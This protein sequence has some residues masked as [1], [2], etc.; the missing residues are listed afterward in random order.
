MRCTQFIFY[1]IMQEFNFPKFESDK[2][3]FPDLE[4]RF[5]EADRSLNEYRI[6]MDTFRELYGAEA[7]DRDRSKVNHIKEKFLKTKTPEDIEAK[8]LAVIFEAVFSEQA[9]LSNWLGEN[10]TVIPTCEYDDIIN[11]VDAI[12]EFSEEE[13]SPQHLG[14]GIDVTYRKYLHEKFKKIKENIDRGTL[15]E[16]KYFHSGSLNFTGKLSQIPRVVVLAKRETVKELVEL[17]EGKKKKALAD[18][19][20]QFQILEEIIM[21]LETY[22]EYALR[23]GKQ[24]IAKKFE[25]ARRIISEI[26]QKKKEASAGSH[27]DGSVDIIKQRLDALFK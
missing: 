9:E 3:I 19:F 25:M 4:R 7:V 6:D 16:I 26:Y 14:L 22:R 12:A 13:K 5:R 18:H 24:D 1:I 11:S 17:Q 10:S 8:K 23:I 2:I 20:I 27:N 21:Q 15:A